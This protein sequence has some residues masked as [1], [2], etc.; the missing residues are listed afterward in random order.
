MVNGEWLM[1]MLL[2]VVVSAVCCLSVLACRLS[3]YHPN[4][5]SPTKRIR[6]LCTARCGTYDS[7]GTVIL[8]K[9]KYH[10]HHVH[11]RPSCVTVNVFM[12]VVL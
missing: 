4:L 5:T 8:T 2:V 3:D 6:P 12:F 10:P 1:M 7:R 9:M 11:T